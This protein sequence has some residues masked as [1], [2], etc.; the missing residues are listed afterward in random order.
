MSQMSPE[1]FRKTFEAAREAVGH[2]VVGHHEVVEQVFVAV[3]AGGHCLL[4]GVPGI[5]KTLM[6]RSVAVGPPTLR[7]PASTASTSRAFCAAAS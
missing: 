4:E 7:T 3:F 2:A 6:V 1:T 5:G